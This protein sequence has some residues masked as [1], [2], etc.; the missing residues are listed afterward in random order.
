MKRE[1]CVRMNGWLCERHEMG[2][3]E[4]TEHVGDQEEVGQG[5]Q[6]A[7]EEEEVIEGCCE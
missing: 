7:E 5:L 6:E 4:S 1:R 3:L 2:K